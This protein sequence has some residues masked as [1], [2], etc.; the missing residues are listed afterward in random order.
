MIA[1]AQDIA[2]YPD[3]EA[4]LVSPSPQPGIGIE[5]VPEIVDSLTVR[6]A[7]VTV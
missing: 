2:S 4:G 7:V 1:L 3:L 5:P 6:R